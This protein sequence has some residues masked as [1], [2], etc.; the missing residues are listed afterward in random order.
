MSQRDPSNSL[1]GN[2]SMCICLGSTPLSICLQC[3]SPGNWS[4]WFILSS[5]SAIYCTDT[6][7]AGPST[8]WNPS[9]NAGWSG[10]KNAWMLDTRC[11]RTMCNMVS[12]PYIQNTEGWRAGLSVWQPEDSGWAAYIKRT[13]L[14]HA[15]LGKGLKS[16]SV[17]THAIICLLKCVTLLSHAQPHLETPIFSLLT[18]QKP[19]R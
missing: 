14:Y 19:L 5:T 8:Q 4:V 2:V 17:C 10:V 6:W 1:T 15:T 13:G 9:T 11:S 3:L 18:F 16:C 7:R 12:S